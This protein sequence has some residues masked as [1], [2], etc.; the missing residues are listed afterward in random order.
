MKVSKFHSYRNIAKY[1]SLICLPQSLSRQYDVAK[2][3]K[4][5]EFK[6]VYSLNVEFV[7]IFLND[8]RPSYI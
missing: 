1:A 7:V 2:I 3:H 6:N 8:V 4:F 5:F